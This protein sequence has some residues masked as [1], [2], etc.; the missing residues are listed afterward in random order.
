MLQV[1]MASQEK[2]AVKNEKRE[3]LTSRCTE[4]GDVLSKDARQVLSAWGNF[5]KVS[6]NIPRALHENRCVA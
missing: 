6:K 5:P 3:G 1:F 4:E 2:R